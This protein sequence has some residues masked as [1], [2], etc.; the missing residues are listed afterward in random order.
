MRWAR[1]KID[2]PVERED[3]NDYR[4]RFILFEPAGPL[5]ACVFT[6]SF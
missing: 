1:R 5:L 4:L 2:I 3:R 6:L